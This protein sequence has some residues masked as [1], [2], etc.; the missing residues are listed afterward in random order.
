M[1]D[2]EMATPIND[3]RQIGDQLKFR[4]KQLGLSIELAAKICGVSKQTYHDL[5]LAK[6]SIKFDTMLKILNA[7]GIS[8]SVDSVEGSNPA[9]DSD[10]VWG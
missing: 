6:G 1:G 7:M 5:E 8:L 2:G 10:D 3:I 4:R 9:H